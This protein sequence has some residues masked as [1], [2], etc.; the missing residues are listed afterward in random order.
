MIFKDL[1]E[2]CNDCGILE[3]MFYADSEMRFCNEFVDVGVKNNDI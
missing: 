2:F 1:K 3:E